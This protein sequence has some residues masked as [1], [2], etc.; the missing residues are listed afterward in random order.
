M[1]K[2]E[3]FKK[4][5]AELRVAVSGKTFSES[6][7]NAELFKIIEGVKAEIAYLERKGEA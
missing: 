4:R 5:L 3:E 7:D 2:I 6:N 1:K